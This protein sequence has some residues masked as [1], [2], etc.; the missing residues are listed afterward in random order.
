MAFHRSRLIITLLLF[1][2]AEASASQLLS[3]KVS[4]FDCTIPSQYLSQIKVSVKCENVRKVA[5]ATTKDD[6]SFKADLPR[7]PKNCVAELLGGPSQ[8]YASEKDKVSPVVKGTEP[9]TY[10]ISTPLGFLTSCPKNSLCEAAKQFGASETFDLPLPPEWGF[11]PSS[12]YV[13]FFP[14]IGIP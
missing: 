9:N 3:A 5:V 6:G 4:C 1:A 12:Y 2:F 14:I 8:L 10:T 11:A 7:D 13:P